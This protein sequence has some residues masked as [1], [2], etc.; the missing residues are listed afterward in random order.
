MLPN[1]SQSKLAPC[2]QLKSFA[3]KVRHTLMWYWKGRCAITGVSLRA[4][5]RASHAEPQWERQT[6]SA[7]MSTTGRI[8]WRPSTSLR[9]E[10]HHPSGRRRRERPRCC[11]PVSGSARGGRFALR[12]RGG[13]GTLYIDC[14][15]PGAC[16][17]TVGASE[18]AECWARPSNDATKPTSGIR[19][20]RFARDWF[21]PLE[22][23]RK[24]SE[25]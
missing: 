21:D 8:S 12:R 25:V 23:K 19:N 5:V 2:A 16:T 3:G 9:L 7:L 4:F 24:P 17:A 13:C 15:A 18:N 20:A 6:A 10:V 22:A 1:T 11:R 14:L